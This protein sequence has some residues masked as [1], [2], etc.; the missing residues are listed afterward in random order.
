MGE[1]TMNAIHMDGVRWDGQ[2]VHGKFLYFVD[3]EGPN[4]ATF[5]Y[6][7]MSVERVEPGDKIGMWKD[8]E[9]ESL[10]T[11][12]SYEVLP[13]EWGKPRLVRVSFEEPLPDFLCAS[14]PCNPYSHTCHYTLENSTFE[15]IAGC[16][17]ILRNDD[18]TIRGCTFVH[19]MYPAVFLGG[20]LNNESVT[21]KNLLV[22]GCEFEDC[23]WES[24][25]GVKGAFAA[26]VLPFK[27][28]PV[29]YIFDLRIVGNTF[30][31][32]PTAISVKGV[33]GIV[34]KD[35]KFENVEV[36]FL[37]NDSDGIVSDIQN[38]SE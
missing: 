10:M 18:S 12:K 26:A 31:D 5:S 14:T 3:A 1:A 17:S 34:L 32:C 7:G 15:N 38:Q 4:T 36:P 28:F 9:N 21:G 27:D 16:A 19:I 8:R 23:A 37:H 13:I 2:N 20:D 35:N 30:R 29:P 25:N 6:N 33:K 11:V 24:R 22:E